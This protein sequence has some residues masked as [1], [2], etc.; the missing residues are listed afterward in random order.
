MSSSHRYY[1]VG[2]SFWS[3]PAVVALSDD[4]RLLALYL[5][6]CPHRTSEGLFRL[7]KA[8]ATADL[9][10]SMERLAE[11]FGQLLANGFIEYDV[12]AQVCLI[13]AAL[14]WQAPVNENVAKAAVARLA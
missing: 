3:D 2:P 10:W 12:D 9:Q 13:V 6:T 5:L 1:R 8:Y 7:P 11:P 4:G 14:K